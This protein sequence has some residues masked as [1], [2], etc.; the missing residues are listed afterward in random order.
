MTRGEITSISMLPEKSAPLPSH[1][2]PVNAELAFEESMLPK[3]VREL[4]SENILHRQ[5]ALNSVKSIS[6]NHE[7][8][9]NFTRVRK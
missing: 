4:K 5:R 7:Q 2:N 3:L 1:L 6:V 9:Y 8:T